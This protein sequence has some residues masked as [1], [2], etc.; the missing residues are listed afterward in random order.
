V[1]TGSERATDAEAARL[2][3]KENQADAVAGLD[4]GE[5]TQDVAGILMDLAKR[6]TR[7][8]SSVFARNLV[9]TLGG[10]VK[11]HKVPLRSAGF[12]VLSAP[13]VPSVLIELGYMSNAEDLARLGKL[14]GQRQLATAIAASIT[15]FFAN[16]EAGTS[17]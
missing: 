7:T 6:E 17:R 3:A 12:R 5:D 4:G 11:M 16:R 9:E 1:Y 10:S 2:A 15:T 14:D 8:F 13:D